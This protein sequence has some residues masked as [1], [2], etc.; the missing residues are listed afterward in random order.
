MP[1]PLILASRSP[2]R[3]QLLKQVRLKFDVVVDNI[4]EDPIRGIS[5]TETVQ[6][7]ALQKAKHVASTLSR[8]VVLGADTLVEYQGRTFKKPMF[9]AEAEEFLLF[10]SGK[11]HRVHTGVAIVDIETNRCPTAC[12][13]TKVTFRN[14]SPSEIKA[15][16]K[17]G[18][19]MD[20]A[21]AYGI[22]G[23]GAIFV[24]KI[25]GS[26]SNVVGLPLELLSSMLTD[27]G[28]RVL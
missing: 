13:T 14:I 4:K 3:R 22:Q 25:V 5:P 12:A 6:A 2:R 16:I 26:Y 8:G 15:Y 9:E 7:M 21:G 17:T 19:P 1:K 11:T 10:L 20:K 27:F 24:D 18:E 23:I 28:I